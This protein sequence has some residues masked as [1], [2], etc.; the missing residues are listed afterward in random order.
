MISAVEAKIPAVP[1]EVSAFNNDAGYLVA[2]DIADKADKAD[3]LAG[4]G[5]GDAYT[6][7]EVDTAIDN[8]KKSI[9]GEGVEEAYNTLK[10]IQDILQGTD[11]EAIDGLVET[12]DANKNAIAT[13]TGDVNTAGS[14]DKKIA[15]AVAPLAT[16]EALNG[17]K[18][19]AEAAQTAEQV[20]SAIESAI[21]EANLGQYAVKTEV[22]TA[23]ADKADADSVVA[24]STFEQF[25]SDNVD[26]IAAARTGAVED[27][28]KVGYALET[29]IAGTYATKNE[30]SQHAADMEATLES[31]LGD[32]ATTAYVNGE[33]A[34]KID[35]ATISHSTDEKAEGA[36]VTGTQLDIVVDAFTK[37]ETRQ[38]VADTIKTMTGGESAADVKLLLEN[39]VAAYTEK[40]GQIDAKDAA[41]DTAIATAQTQA[42]KGVADAKTANDAIAALTTGAVATNTSDITTIKGR[43][44][45]LETAKGNH[46]QRITNAEGKITALEAADVVINGTLTTINGEIST[47]K[48]TD[49]ELLA[50]IQANT[51]KF[52]GY[53][54]KDEVDEAVQGAIDA[55]PDVDFT[56]YATETYVT[57]AITVVNG[58]VAKKA[59]A[60]AL[61]NYYT[62]TD[63]D[64]AF[65]TEGEVDAR[66]NAL[67]NAA[68]P[69][70]GK[71]I[72]DIQNLVKYVE[73]NAGEIA[74]L[75]TTVGEHTTA[76]A[77]NKTA[78]E[79][80]ATAIAQN[81]SDIAALVT[82]VAANEVKESSEI[83]VTAVEG[84]G[85]T[86]VQ[87][88]IKAVNVN[89]LV[90]TEG[91]TL[92]LN[93]GAAV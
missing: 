57:D 15:D 69:E 84:E 30:L 87:L 16:T 80:N 47:L 12:V 61:D 32:Y 72:S 27:V 62:K 65:M 9:L 36:T 45:T 5:I 24:N 85:A 78:H 43:L 39:H 92:I 76:I 93:G 35:K 25:K 82:S 13:L 60:S 83:S 86:G 4:Y 21:T 33:L 17:V 38:Y 70:G 90:Q 14:V 54:T 20:E 1:T 48:S 19:T 50:A 79:N 67:I 29:T 81:T 77:N 3:T 63:A 74:G 42:D 56:G 46:E 58:E 31:T 26:A 40:V 51:T 73:E 10:E 23:L 52:D 68:D 55:I 28:A 75:V 59:D 44:D 11:G 89:K 22:E 2:A 91:D 34:K 49:A 7:T 88:G 37:A 6:K 41:Q 18:A 66:I 8:A 64:A 53:Y 71:V